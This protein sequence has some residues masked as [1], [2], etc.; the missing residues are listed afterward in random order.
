MIAKNTGPEAVYFMICSLVSIV[1]LKYM[2]LA[3]G[4]D[5]YVGGAARH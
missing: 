5:F 2:V 1:S 4:F 3:P